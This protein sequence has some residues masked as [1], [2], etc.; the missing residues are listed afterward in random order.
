MPKAQRFQT[1]V[2]PVQKAQIQRR[3]AEARAQKKPVSW[4]VLSRREDVPERTLQYWHAKWIETQGFYDDPLAVVGETLDT[5]SAQIEQVSVDLESAESDNAKIGFNRVLMDLMVKRIN[6]LIQVGR[7][8]RNIHDFESAGDVRQM[9][10][11]M[12]EVVE[13]HDLDPEVIEDLL[14]IVEAQKSRR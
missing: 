4:A 9:I 10:I 11:Q 1:K 14:S 5:L 13:K 7:M 12:A 8:P 3:V 2:G 6:L